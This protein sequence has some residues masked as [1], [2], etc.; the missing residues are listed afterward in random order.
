MARRSGVEMKFRVIALFVSA[1]T[2]LMAH[3]ASP[4]GAPQF[5]AFG[6]DLDA[7]DAKVR[8]G[9]DFWAYANGGWSA[10]TVIAGDVDAVGVAPTLA[11]EG[12][13]RV[14]ILLDTL[15]TGEDATPSE[16][17]VGDLYASWMA[18]AEIDSRG[19]RTARPYLAKIAQARTHQALQLLM[20]D[21][22]Y[23]AP[24]R[25][26][27]GADPTDPTSNLVTAAQ[28]E[29]GMPRDYFLNPDARY[30]AI[31]RD[32]AGYVERILQAGGIPEAGTKAAAI[33]ALE[34]RLARS[35]STP[36]EQREDARTRLMS[37]KALQA[38]IP[39][40]DWPRMLKAAGLEGAPEVLVSD[41]SA[42]TALGDLL[43]GEPTSLW[44]DYLA[45]RFLS[46]HAELLPRP[47][48]TARFDFY[49]RTLSGVTAPPPR[50]RRGVALMNQEWM[51]D[52]VG[53]AYVARYFPPDAERQV[54]MIFDDVKAAFQARIEQSTWMD[55][56]TK[57]G[58][59]EKLATLKARIG[60]AGQVQDYSG[61][62][63]DRTDLLGNVLRLARFK[64]E[65][66]RLSLATTNT[67]DYPVTP[68]SSNGYYYAAANSITLE[69]GLLRPPFF[70]PSAD[71]A[72]NYGA[73]GVFIG[74]EMGHAF[75][76]QGSRYDASGRVR[77]WWS[78]A[79]R[80]GFDQ[81]IAALKAQY[82]AYDVLPGL[83]VDGALT[84]GENIADLGGLEA[85][86]AAYQHYLART[87]PAPILNGLT[88]DQRFFLAQAQTRRTKLRE[89]VA[90]QLAAIDTH[91][92]SVLRTNAVMRN[93]DAWYDAFDVAPT[94]RLYLA[95]DQRVRIW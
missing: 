20:A 95:P 2:P 24:I 72:V 65:R 17:R 51:G 85:A 73:I 14:R 93:N 13:E 11:R 50:W 81:R 21:V 35:Q 22:A 18:Q 54:R 83:K 94:D 79:S 64:R 46:E 23:A 32:Y 31:R 25:F 71:P 28:G 89:D 61:L 12:Q 30:V 47:F 75:D 62:R 36:A 77:D 88:G 80:A 37:P 82:G 4:P 56:Q 76:D 67:P 5:G 68:V 44:K 43:T 48:A 55:A 3:A 63:V 66:E 57:A 27:V 15:A 38:E 16:R 26:G 34:T 90:R 29:L 53:A 6:V 39:Q 9:D 52:A 92:P 74:H 45:Y 7:R 84:L 91:A 86:Y 60:S 69:A 59:L 49:S 33:C 42:L 40:W 10:R 1:L 58:A 41:T 70:D 78:A 19:L 8:P 87:G